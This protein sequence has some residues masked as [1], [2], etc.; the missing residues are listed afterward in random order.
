MVAEARVSRLKP[1]RR[2]L[3]PVALINRYGTS[4]LNSNA[5]RNVD[6]IWKAI[7][8]SASV[9][10]PP[11]AGNWL[12]PTDTPNLELKTS[13]LAPG[14]F[15][16][17]PTKKSNLG[18]VEADERMIPLRTNKTAKTYLYSVSRWALVERGLTV[19]QP[20]TVLGMEVQEVHERV[21]E[22]QEEAF[23]SLREQVGPWEAGWE[24]ADRT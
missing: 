4:T 11:D 7:Y 5:S 24:V 9:C 3:I 16:H 8:N 23:D 19:M 21:N 20:W 14:L 17:V 15:V 13:P 2:R 18:L 1:E 12:T 22:A 10:A 6:E